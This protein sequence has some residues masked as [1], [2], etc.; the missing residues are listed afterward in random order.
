MS[1]GKL[2]QM[3]GAQLEKP[4]R[5]N[6]ERKLRISVLQRRVYSA[7]LVFL[8]GTL[9]VMEEDNYAGWEVARVLCVKVAIL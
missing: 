8:D 1:T 6:S 2:F 9:R 7:D 5:E 4:R 3:V